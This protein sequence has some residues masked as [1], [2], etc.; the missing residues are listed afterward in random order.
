M[1]ELKIDTAG[2]SGS[3]LMHRI[4]TR[5]AHV[6]IVCALLGIATGCFTSERKSK[7][8]PLEDP[9]GTAPPDEPPGESGGEENFAQVYGTMMMQEDLPLPL[10]DD[11]NMPVPSALPGAPPIAAV[12]PAKSASEIA[13]LLQREQ[14]SQPTDDQR[15]AMAQLANVVDPQ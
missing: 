10:V 11:P 8:D 7:S 2:F 14:D 15:A 4:L 1:N 12:W 13:A 9:T 3:S 6:L 5:I